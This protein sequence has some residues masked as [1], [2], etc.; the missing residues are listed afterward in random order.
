MF[1][2]RLDYLLTNIMKLLSVQYDL[3]AQCHIGGDNPTYSRLLWPHI[4]CDEAEQALLYRPWHAGLDGPPCCWKAEFG[5][6]N[7]PAGIRHPKSS[8]LFGAVLRLKTRFCL[9][10]KQF[11]TV[12]QQYIAF[13][14]ETSFFE[15]GQCLW[16]MLKDKPLCRDGGETK[17]TFIALRMQANKKIFSLLASKAISDFFILHMAAENWANGAYVL[18]W[19]PED[20]RLVLTLTCYINY[21]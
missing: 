11:Y 6:K 13:S 18:P 3:P 16:S 7:L 2:F 10:S 14:A 15:E 9:T 4:G 17:A 19:K 20:T 1:I 5:S 21:I 12:V 8:S